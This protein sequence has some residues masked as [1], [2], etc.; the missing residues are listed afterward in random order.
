[1]EFG[2]YAAYNEHLDIPVRYDPAL[3]EDSNE[4]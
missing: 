3:N 2:V 1:M 4:A